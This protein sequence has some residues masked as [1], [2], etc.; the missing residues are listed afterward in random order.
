MAII[1]NFK[2]LSSLTEQLESIRG[3]VQACLSQLTEFQKAVAMLRQQAEDA[4]RAR[5]TARDEQRKFIE[6]A[7]KEMDE[8][9]TVRYQL[10]RELQSFEQM[11]REFGVT[12]AARLENEL[13][14]SITEATNVLRGKATDLTVAKE[15]L[16]KLSTLAIRA[17][18]SLE[19]LHGVA[20]RIKD[21]DFDFATAA[22]TIQRVEQEKIELQQRVDRAEDY[23]AKQVKRMRDIRT[24]RQ[25][26]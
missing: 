3:G 17:Q 21:K 19:R 25:T 18:Q 11:K 14:S 2:A 26:F 7:K 10:A 1:E 12:V 20:E 6:T 8:I 23:A 4:T 22:A 24:P 16:E 13:R 15:N 9:V 5:D